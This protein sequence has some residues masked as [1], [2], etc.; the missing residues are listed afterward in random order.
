MELSR[1]F[2][3]IIDQDPMPIVIC[4]LMHMI[5]YMNPAAIE[6]YSDDGGEKLI[7]L[8]IFD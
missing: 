8:L 2:K 6:T 5:V 4:D 3:S 1:F 7:G